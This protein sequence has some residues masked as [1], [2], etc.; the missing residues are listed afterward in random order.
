[1]PTVVL[2]RRNLLAAGGSVL[3]TRGFRAPVARPRARPRTE[4]SFDAGRGQQLSQ[5]RGDRG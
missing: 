4:S 5:G 1:M 2:N 3:A